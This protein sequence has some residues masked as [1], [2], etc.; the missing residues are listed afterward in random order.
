MVSSATQAPDTAH[1]A[2]LPPLAPG[3]PLFGTV[4][5]FRDPIRV[6]ASMYQQLGSVYR[7]RVLWRTYTILA[8]PEAISFFIKNDGTLLSSKKPYARASRELRTQQFISAL[9]GKAHLHQRAILKPAFSPAAINGYIPKMFWAAKEVTGSWQPGQV[10]HMKPAMQRL[11][12][13]QLVF[14]MTNHVLDERATKDAATF[15]ETLNGAAIAGTRP[16][17]L[18]LHPAYLVAKRRIRALMCQ[19]IE[20]RRQ[21]GF[22]EQAPDLLDV[23]L[24]AS[25]LEGQPLDEAV[26]I[27]HLQLP[28][29]AG[30]D[31][32]AALAGCTLYELDQQP[33][34]RQQVVAE[35]DEAF[36]DGIPTAQAFGQMHTLH[37]VVLETF[38]K[39]PIVTAV[40]RRAEGD[41][42]FQG[43]RVKQGQRVLIAT[44]AAHLSP[45]FFPDPLTFDAD[46]WCDP[47][48]EQRQATVFAPFSKGRH[49]CVGAGIAETGVCT[50]VAAALHAVRLAVDPPGYR[51]RT[52]LNPLPGPEDTFSM[53]VLEQRPHKA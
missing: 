43:H 39:Y 9:S 15:S 4:A 46:R 8:G 41:F 11:V 45:H 27:E 34:L 22:H 20:E 31:T 28:F 36:T 50:T 38:R 32:I 40:Q 6:F 33:T 19:L 13:R 53:R 51:L 24:S 48:H 29:L 12:S 1:T 25:D 49:T 5:I 23:I 21:Q 26:L 42:E 2:P 3:V 37:R 17:L 47:H 10:L 30:M 7:V 14:A 52:T 44:T 16:A 35:V 18:L